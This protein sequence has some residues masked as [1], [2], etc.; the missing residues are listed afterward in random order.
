MHTVGG[1]FCLHTVGEFLLLTVDFFV[2]HLQGSLGPSGPETRKSLKNLAKGKYGCTEVRVYPTECGEQLGTDP[3]KI[4]SS[5]SLVLKG[6]SGEGTLWDSSLPVSLTLWDT[7]ALFTPPL[8]LP[9]K[10]SP[11]ASGPVW[12]PENV[13]KKSFWDLFETFFQTLE[14]S[15]RLFRDSRR[16]LEPEAPGDFLQ[17]MSGFRARRARETPVKWSTDSRA[18]SPFRWSETHTHT[19]S[20]CKQKGFNSKQKN[21][22]AEAK[23]L[24]NSTI[25]EKAHLGIGK[26][27]SKQG[28]GNQR[29]YRRYGPDT[30]IQYRPRNPH[31]LAKPCRILSRR[32]ADTEFQYRPPIVDTDMIADAI[33]ADAISETSSSTISRKL[34]T[35]CKKSEKVF[36]N[37]KRVSGFPEKGADLRGSAGNFRGSPGNFRGS[38][39]KLPGN[40]DCCKVPQ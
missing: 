35:V 12:P 4:G 9:R 10:T 37:Q 18:Y 19:H 5:K 34:S 21:P 7:P 13:S 38:L 20:Q 11:G 14:T 24:P 23:N 32:E 8:P 27:G 40:L 15:S 1:V 33:F 22:R 2:D 30:E 25:R 17:T 29:R 28:R 36:L 6:F 3:S 16:A 26:G 39:G 31:E